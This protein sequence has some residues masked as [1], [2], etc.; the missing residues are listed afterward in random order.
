MLGH[1][2][3]LTVE[4]LSVEFVTGGR[5]IPA[6]RNV[7]FQLGR[8]R[9]GIVG[10]SGSGKSSVARALLGLLPSSAIVT[11]DRLVLGA[12]DLRRLGR[13]EW[14][15]IRGRRIAMILQDAKYSL[16]PIRRVGPQI[17]E[18]GLL[19]ERL[20]RS[21]A[22]QRALRLLHAVQIRDPVQ[23]YNL[24]P[25][26]LS[27]GMAQRV[28][29]AMMLMAEPDVLIADEATSALDVTVQNSIVAI[30]DRLVAERGMG[31]L[32][33]SHNLNLVSSSATVPWSCMAEGP[34]DIAGLRFRC[35]QSSLYARAAGGGTGFLSSEIPSPCGRAR[36][37][38]ASVNAPRFAIEIGSLS[39][40]FQA[41]MDG[42]PRCGVC[43]SA[44]RQVNVSG[45]SGRSGSGKS[46]VLRAI[47][48]LTPAPAVVSPST[49]RSW[50]RTRSRADCRLMQLVFQDPYAA[51]HPRQTVDRLL[52]EPLE[53]QGVDERDRR[54][55]EAL[56]AVDLD[57]RCRFRYPHQLSGGQRQRVAIARALV[58]EPRILL[59]DEPT[60]A[61]D[62]SVQAEI[63]NL[64]RRLRSE[65]R[66]TSILVSHDLAV[67][68]HLC[69]R[70]GV[71]RAGRFLEIL[72]ARA[73]RQ[74]EA[75][76]EYT[77][78]LIVASR[79]YRRAWTGSVN[80]SIDCN[81]IIIE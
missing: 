58:L 34:G 26:Q 42:W 73:L 50:G 1:Q 13:T 5:V 68:A 49:G 7:S 39:V 27:G 46:T 77:R 70:V 10:E 57:L 4:N 44:S 29:I 56:A 81:D 24:H 60:S 16:N 72:T 51:L 25:D 76:H 28:M 15:A 45:S 79:G 31:L 6:V 64:L 22:R 37:A 74:G 2:P 12:R 54:I 61:L 65:R 3:L 52:R 36:P 8:E 38:V 14:P 67:V 41:A 47:A 18:T 53:I 11:A 20:S 17:A 23:V 63:L 62:L 19:F 78:D 33:I 21:E 43:P 59:L 66:L 32:F 71:M 40:S 48:G 30:L 9:L 75:A 69:T 80:E 55:G 35:R